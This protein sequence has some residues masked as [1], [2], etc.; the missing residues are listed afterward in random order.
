MQSSIAELCHECLV[1]KCILN[2]RKY[3]SVKRLREH[4]FA[5]S[6]NPAMTSLNICIHYTYIFLKMIINMKCVFFR[7]YLVTW[8]RKRNALAKQ[9]FLN[10]IETGN[11]HKVSIHANEFPNFKPHDKFLFVHQPNSHRMRIQFLNRFE[12]FSLICANMR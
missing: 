1:S 11:K 9:Q 4:D 8:F 6:S 7:P 2:N 5:W 10:F 12:L 3:R